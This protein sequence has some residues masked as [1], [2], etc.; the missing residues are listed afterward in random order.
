MKP[1]VI[2]PAKGFILIALSLAIAAMGLYVAG[3]DDVVQAEQARCGRLLDLEQMS[4]IAPAVAGA[5][6][7]RA[8][9]VEWRV[10]GR[11][12]GVLHVNLAVAREGRAV[13]T[14]TGLHHAI[15]LVDA[16]RNRSDE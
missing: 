4:E 16:V 10:A 6:L 14:Q 1:T 12:R 11:V 5:D 15:E 9:L 3:A 7:A 13:S 8:A 2:N